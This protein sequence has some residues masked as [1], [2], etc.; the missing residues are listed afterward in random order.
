MVRL[1]G[2]DKG[3]DYFQSSFHRGVA[4]YPR[5]ATPID[6]FQSSFHRDYLGIVIDK[7]NNLAFNPLFIE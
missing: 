1:F 3:L 7:A 6:F 5:E 2:W 4:G